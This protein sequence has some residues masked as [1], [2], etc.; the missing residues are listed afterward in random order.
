MKFKSLCINVNQVHECVPITLLEPPAGLE[1]P[2]GGFHHLKYAFHPN[3]R[4]PHATC[5]VKCPNQPKMLQSIPNFSGTFTIP[6]VTYSPNFT[7]ILSQASILHKSPFPAIVSEP[8]AQ[9][10]FSLPTIKPSAHF[11]HIYPY[12]PIR[13]V[14]AQFQI[15]SC[16]IFNFKPP[17][18]LFH[19]QTPFSR[20]LTS[21]SP[22]L[23]FSV[24]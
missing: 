5:S 20:R 13:E 9:I 8:S 22:Y 24:P 11:T 17:T 2:L 3:P 21:R 16:L 10:P 4:T 23:S 15:I 7:P 14:S 6:L 12:K 18:A 1:L 19:V